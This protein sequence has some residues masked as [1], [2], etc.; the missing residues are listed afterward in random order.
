MIRRGFALA[1]IVA[2]LLTSPVA[3][4]PRMHV[5]VIDKLKFGP[6]PTGVRVG[7]TIVW[8]NRDIFRH[9]ATS[10]SGGFDIDLAAGKSGKS[11]VKTAG[12]FPFV[13][14]FHPGMR[15]VLKVAK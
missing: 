7:D 10:K 11:V 13:C 3:A 9:T 15:G 12:A 5:M 1:P 8:Q 14:K 4:A 2:L 6:A